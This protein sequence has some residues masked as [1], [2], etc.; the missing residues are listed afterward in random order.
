[1]LVLFHVRRGIYLYGARVG[2][3]LVDA[4]HQLVADAALVSVTGCR[5]RVTEIH[6]QA[7]DDNTD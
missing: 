5:G 7:K 3:F 1:M 6:L 2:G 4:L